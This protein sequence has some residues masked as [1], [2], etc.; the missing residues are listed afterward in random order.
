VVGPSTEKVLIVSEG[1]H[2]RAA[3]DVP[4]LLNALNEAI[5]DL[6][7]SPVARGVL[8]ATEPRLKFGI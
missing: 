6:W 1:V 4:S 2:D 5:G 8:T 3:R 7:E